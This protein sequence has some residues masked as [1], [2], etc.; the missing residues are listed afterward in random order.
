MGTINNNCI[1]FYQQCIKAFSDTELKVIMSIGGEVELT[2]LGSVPGNFIVKNYVP[3]LKV[4]KKTDV[5]ISH[6]GLNSVSEALYF[7][8]PI[9]AIPQANDQPMVMKQLVGLGAGI[10]LKMEEVTSQVLSEAVYKLLSDN[11]YRAAAERIG[12]SFMEAGGYKTAADFIFEYT[13]TTLR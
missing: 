5:F 6:G 4:L 3:Q 12:S 13:Q 11:T 1:E 9:I 10:G 7:G 2:S 8:I